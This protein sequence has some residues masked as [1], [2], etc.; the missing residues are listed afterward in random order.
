MIIRGVS[1]WIMI[2]GW[3]WC[4]ALMDGWGIRNCEYGIDLLTSWTYRYISGVTQ[5]VSQSCLA[6]KRGKTYP[7]I[8]QFQL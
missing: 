5:I 2:Q 7:G 1:Y 8:P 6:Q 4:K 3:G